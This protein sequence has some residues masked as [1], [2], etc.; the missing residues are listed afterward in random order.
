M[1]MPRSQKRCGG[2]ARD[3]AGRRPRRRPRRDRVQAG[4]R[5]DQR[6]LAGAVRAR[7]PPPARRPRSRRSTSRHARP[8]RRSSRA[9]SASTSSMRRSRGR[10]ST[11]SGSRITSARRALGDRLAIGEHHD[12]VGELHHRA[13][14][15]LDEHDGRAL[16]ADGADQAQR[17]VHLRRRQAGEHLVEEQQLRPRR[18]RARELEELSFVQVQLGRKRVRLFLQSGELE[19]APGLR[20]GARRD[21]STTWPNIGGRATFCST[22]SCGNGRGIW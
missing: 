7:P 5:V 1:A 8:P 14:H 2:S 4:H 10:P 22:V 3:V 17:P 19:P 9:T 20:L 12:A 6:R 15:V 16:V 18:Q 13:H 21:P 11:T